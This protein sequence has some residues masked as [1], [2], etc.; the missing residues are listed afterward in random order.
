M[1]KQTGADLVKRTTKVAELILG[2][3]VIACGDRVRTISSGAV[4]DVL[5][6]DFGTRML[7][8]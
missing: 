3:T 2:K 6:V 8:P 1:C 4:V 7:L 5:P